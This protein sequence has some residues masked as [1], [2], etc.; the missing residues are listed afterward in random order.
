MIKILLGTIV[1][2]AN[3]KNRYRHHRGMPGPH[4]L[5]GMIHSVHGSLVAE[6]WALKISDALGN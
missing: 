1:T 4:T 5:G 3:G 2:I 6:T